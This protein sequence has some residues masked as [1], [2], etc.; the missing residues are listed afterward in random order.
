MVAMI[1]TFGGGGGGILTVEQ[2][3]GSNTYVN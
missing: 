2:Y 1:V 3:E